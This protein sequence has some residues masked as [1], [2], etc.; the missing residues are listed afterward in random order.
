M[1]NGVAGL[2][3]LTA[4]EIEGLEPYVAGAR[5]LHVP[6]TGIIDFSAV[7]RAYADDVR[8]AGGEI[9][10]ARVV[11]SIRTHHGRIELET[12]HGAVVAT[13]AIACAGLQSD[14]LLRLAGARPSPVRIVPFRGDYYTLVER[15]R[16]LVR[17]LIYPVP[18]PAFPFLGIHFTPMIDGSVTVGPNAVLSLAR[19]G[20]RRTAFNLRDTLSTLTYG[21]FWRFAAHH[22]SSG[23]VEVV[24][25]VSKRAFVAEMRRYVPAVNRRDVVFGP[26]GIRAQALKRDGTLVDDFVFAQSDRMMHVVNAPSPGATAAIAIARHIAQRIDS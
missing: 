13:R 4:R 15:A 3:D 16:G 1:T 9:H 26:C 23:V 12:P 2:R 6:G 17:G 20:Y 8:H 24:R 10:L 5:A 7:S 25:D 18:D 14:R 19:E 11:T 21:G 22:L